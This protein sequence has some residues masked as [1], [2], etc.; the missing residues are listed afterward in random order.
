VK[1]FHAATFQLL[2]DLPRPSES[3]IL[4]CEKAERRLRLTLPAS[5]RE[6]Y[7]CDRAIE[8]LLEHSNDDPP[9]AVS[10][11]TTAQSGPGLLLP[12]RT[13]NQG[14]C[15]WAILLNGSEDPPVLVSV[16]SNG[17]DWCNHAPSF[18]TYVRASVWDYKVVH[19]APLLVQAQNMP[20]SS[21]A[22]QQLEQLF[23][24][25][26]RT[27]GWPGSAQYRF[28]GNDFGLLIWAAEN[29]AGWI[30]G[31]KNEASLESALRILWA[32]DQVGP[33][34]SDCS[35]NTEGIPAR[36]RRFFGY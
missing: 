29:Q 2:E 14:V 15:I 32:I 24:A 34:L 8:I 11:L 6:W 4:E 30:V 35:E 21:E 28:R 33:S 5:V 23:P 22:V 19:H 1:S 36:V 9:I 17:Q 12:F 20:L 13:E 27:Y 3:A 7:S 31:A 16:D 18:S 25:E 26:P 10:R